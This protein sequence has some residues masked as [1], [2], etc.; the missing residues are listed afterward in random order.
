MQMLS[1]LITAAVELAGGD[2][3]A[4]GGRMWQSE[5]GRACPLGWGG[6]SQTV[7]VDLKTG[8]YDYGQPGGPGHADCMRHC[9]HGREPAPNSVLSG[10]NAG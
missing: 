8:E 4:H 3:V 9:R 10:K 5:G 1:D 6:C 7:Y 2:E